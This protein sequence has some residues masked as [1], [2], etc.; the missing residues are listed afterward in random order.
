M[1]VRFLVLFASG[2]NTAAHRTERLDSGRSA[3]APRDL[4]LYYAEVAALVEWHGEIECDPRDL[5]A[6]GREPVN[7][8]TPIG[9]ASRVASPRPRGKAVLI[10]QHRCL[11]RYFDAQRRQSNGQLF[12]SDGRRSGRAGWSAV[13]GPG[14]CRWSVRPSSGPGAVA[15]LAGLPQ[16]RPHDSPLGVEG[17]ASRRVG[18]RRVR[19]V[20]SLG[21]PGAGLVN[22]RH[23]RLADCGSRPPQATTVVPRLPATTVP[24][25]TTARHPGRSVSLPRSPNNYTRD[26]LSV[27]SERRRRR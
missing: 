13:P 20:T 23:Q 27:L 12:G 2:R 17:G 6:A 8:S 25:G 4:L 5:L 16:P 18:G 24:V 19:P 26:C 9:R 10:C 11:N 15:R 22:I 21:S 3:T 14:C 1:V 7:L